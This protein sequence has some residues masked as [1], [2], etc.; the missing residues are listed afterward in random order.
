M[1]VN[2]NPLGNV[3]PS[4]LAGAGL[5]TGIGGNLCLGYAPGG[6]NLC[7][8]VISVA[9]LGLFGSTAFAPYLSFAAAFG[10]GFGSSSDT[11]STFCGQSGWTA[12][13]AQ[14]HPDLATG[15]N[16]AVALTGLVDS[17]ALGVEVSA[18]SAASVAAGGAS[19]STAGYL[20]SCVTGPSNP[21]CDVAIA[22]IAYTAL[23]DLFSV[24]WDAF[25]PAQF[26]GSLL[27][28]PS[29]FGG[30]GTAPIG[31]PNQNLSITGILGQP[32]HSSMPSPGLNIQ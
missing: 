5:A 7:N 13:L 2:G 25:G 28:R 18:A 32:S 23:N 16:D 29:D 22:L 21:V 15:I 17:V 9:S 1:Y 6:L 14:D 24:F 19:I 27:P 11:K 12:L 10:C 31:I 3:D 26:T 20:W 4:G 8:P 30:L